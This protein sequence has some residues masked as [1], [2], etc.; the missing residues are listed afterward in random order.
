MIAEKECDTSWHENDH[1][2][3]KK[4]TAIDG[5]NDSERVSWA[6]QTRLK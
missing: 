2:F 4:G 1:C 5:E 6:A 3:K